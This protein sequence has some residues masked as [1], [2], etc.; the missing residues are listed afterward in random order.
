[1]ITAPHA[2]HVEIE[3]GMPCRACQAFD[4]REHR[5]IVMEKVVS[6]MDIVHGSISDK[7]V[8]IYIT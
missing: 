7:V 1:V 5:R 4:A 8:L 3:H 6:V 2:V